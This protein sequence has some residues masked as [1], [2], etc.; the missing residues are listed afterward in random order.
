MK[1]ALSSSATC[2]LAL[3]SM[4]TSTIALAQV[5]REKL[6]QAAT[7]NAYKSNPDKHPIDNQ[8]LNSKS[9]AN[10]LEPRLLIKSEAPKELTQR[11]A[12]I[13]AENQNVDANPNATNWQLQLLDQNISSSAERS[14][15]LQEA[16]NK[17]NAIL[18]VPKQVS[19]VLLNNQQ[20]ALK[21]LSENDVRSFGNT[22]RNPIQIDNKA[23]LTDPKVPLKSFHDADKL[24]QATQHF[25]SLFD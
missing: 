15:K 18:K 6:V 21:T 22:P 5:D 7:L 17:L 3:A 16:T 25:E 20:S 1:N 9:K 19:G 13:G 23:V 11:L 8:D 12:P 10:S 14:G 4:L 2:L 24:K